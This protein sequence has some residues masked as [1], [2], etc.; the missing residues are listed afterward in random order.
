[1][2]ML[3]TNV[4]SELMRQQPNELVINWI[5]AQ[6]KAKIV[7]SAITVAEILTGIARLPEGK[8]KAHF[9]GIANNMFSHVFAERILPFDYTAAKCHAEIM[10]LRERSGKPISMADAQIAAICQSTA[11]ANTTPTLVTRNIKD[12]TNLGLTLINPWLQE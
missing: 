8:R 10:A 6:N 5:D 12:F 11:L 3:D 2:I 9:L 7:I 4:L 1:M